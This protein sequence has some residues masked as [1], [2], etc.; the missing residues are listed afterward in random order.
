[1]KAIVLH[2]PAPVEDNPL[3][4]QDVAEPQPGIDQVRLKVE[5][6]GLCH[7]DLH[8]IEAELPLPKLPLIPGHQV[9]GRV[10]KL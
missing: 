6:C 7:T 10:D 9:V 4:L 2:K 3:L 5:A 8:E 1:M